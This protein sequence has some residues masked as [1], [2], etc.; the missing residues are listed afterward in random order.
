MN[1]KSNDAAKLQMRYPTI[2]NI[3]ATHDEGCSEHKIGHYG[4]L[5]EL[6]EKV[7]ASKN[8]AIG[9]VFACALENERFVI[10]KQIAPASCE[11]M[12]ITQNG[13]HDVLTAYRFGQQ[14][15]V[16]QLVAYVEATPSVSQQA[17]PVQQASATYFDVDGI[18]AVQPDWFAERLQRVERLVPRGAPVAPEQRKVVLEWLHING[19][20]RLAGGGVI[21]NY[22]LGP[23]PGTG[24]GVG[25]SF[26]EG[27]VAAPVVVWAKSIQGVHF[28]EAAIIALNRYQDG[29]RA[30]ASAN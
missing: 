1:E 10:M 16:D 24:E 23:E 4:T 15:L 13:F 29:L 26:I 3:L 25:V 5:A 2:A 20:V 27:G 18:E 19:V 7:R 9:E 28:E 17:S 21:R 8:W 22:V 11:M 14:E 12:T 6:A 30:A